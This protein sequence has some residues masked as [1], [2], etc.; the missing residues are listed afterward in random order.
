MKSQDS[1]AYYEVNARLLC[2]R[3]LREKDPAELVPFLQMLSPGGRVLDLGSGTGFDLGWMQKAGM[4]AVG[5]ENS[6]SRIQLSLEWNP[7]LTVLQ[8]NFLFYTPKE[9]EWDGVWA[10]RSLHHFD[11][12][13]VQRV[14]A[15]AFRG[16]K[17]GGAIGVVVY[18]GAESFEDRAIDLHGPS[19]YL[20]PWTEKAISS[21]LEQSGFKIERI[22][23]RPKDGSHPLPSL[24]V[25]ARKVG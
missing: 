10:S 8:K 9:A 24:L 14:V 11:P 20:R 17:A 13:A 22:G 18:E 15:S 5:I 25:L 3:E 23:R 6:P 12:E 19:R 16:L 7:G 21:L 2:D 4:D 1:D